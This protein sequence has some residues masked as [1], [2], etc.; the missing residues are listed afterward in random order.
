MPSVEAP[1]AN[2][3]NLLAIIQDAYKGKVVVPEFQRSF[4]WGREDIEELLVS[5]LLGYFIGTFLMLDTAPQISLFPFR[6]VEGLDDVNP[7]AA[8]SSPSTVRLVLDGQQRIT[9]LFYALF[10]PSIPLKWSRYPYQFYLRLDRALSGDIEDAIEGISLRDRPRMTEMK[11]EVRFERAV[12]FSLLRDSS[13]F[14]NWLYKKQKRWQTTQQQSEIED[15]YNRLAQFMT[16]VVAL[17]PETGRDNI[18]SIFERI[19]RTGVSLS[20]FDLAG[21]R[22]YLKGVHLRDLWDKFQ[23]THREV[24]KGIKPEFLLKVVALLEGKEPRKGNLLDV[25]DK[26]D[27]P[28]FE[29]RW[30]ESVDAIVMARDR[31]AKHY[32]ALTDDWVPYSTMTV[33]LAAMLHELHRNRAGE[34]AYRKLDRW[35]WGNVFG[36]RYD[37]SVDTKSYQ[38]VRDIRKWVEQGEA[39]EWI[40]RLDVT[41]VDLDVSEPRSAI[42]RGLM[43]MVVLRGALDFL[44]GQPANLSECQDDHIFPKSVFGRRHPVDTIGNRTLISAES[45][46]NTHKTKGNKKPSAFMQL[47]LE[48]HDND[49]LRLLHTLQSHFISEEAYL[50]LM[51]DDFVTFTSARRQSLAP[52]VQSLLHHG[53]L[54]AA[55]AV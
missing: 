9:S 23:K 34:D 29:S 25:I 8:K 14:Y 43:C 47:C 26:L 38:D 41:R 2:P 50:A 42:Y 24:A 30:L 4:V 21:A 20:L 12:K 16:P 40:A 11:Y 32:G 33:P 55:S 27:K 13:S 15:L 28:G 36:Q 45:N 18:V 54:H 51:V 3:E 22:L 19:N 46:A 39:P 6:N 7:D 44:T 48:Q 17:S 35:Y 53:M 37:S 1:K 10:E 52:V 49:E 31:I 5:I